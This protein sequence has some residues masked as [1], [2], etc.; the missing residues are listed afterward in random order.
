VTISW[1]IRTHRAYSGR[2]AQ[3][4]VSRPSRHLVAI[5]LA[6]AALVARVRRRVPS[7]ACPAP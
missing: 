4:Q 3:S 2:M 6:G 7:T 1:V 5:P